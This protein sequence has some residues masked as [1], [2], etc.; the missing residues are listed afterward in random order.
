[1]ATPVSKGLF[2]K[3]IAQ[4]CSGSLHLA[5]QEEAAAAAYGLAKQLGLERPS[6]EALQAIPM[7]RLVAAYVAAPRPYRPV[8]DGRTFTR[9]PCHPDAPPL[10]P[11]IPFMTGNTATETRLAMA[12]DCANFSLDAGEVR[13]RIAR[14]LQ[15]DKAE[16]NRIMDAYQSA[17]PDASASDLMAAVTSD[18]IYRRNTVTAAALQSAAGRARVFAY[19]FDWRTPVWDGRLQAPHM[20]EVPFVFGTTEAAANLVGTGP[21]L[22]SLTAT[23]IATWSAFAHTGDPN[24]SCLPQ[25]PRYDT[26]HALMMMLGPT[27][28]VESDPGACA[29]ESLAAVPFYEYNMPLNYTS[30]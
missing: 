5:G 26:K 16:T 12:A 28:R 8:L 9:N 22:A 1:M 2:H 29:R 21:D 25:W 17:D 27:S 19:V 20:L 24:N 6:G 15:I 11:E 7:D 10:S 3:A 30:P 18:Y 23:M 4:S 14:F 13:R